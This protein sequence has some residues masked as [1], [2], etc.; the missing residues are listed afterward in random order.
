[1]P[2]MS[3][4]NAKRK[5]RQ[6][7]QEY[8]ILFG[9]VPSF[10]KEAVPMCLLCEKTFCNDAMKPA[11]VTDDLERIHSDKDKGLGC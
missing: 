1:M 5:Y 4:T 11:M 7:S 6:Y 2:V 8:Q 10:T 9:F 3:A